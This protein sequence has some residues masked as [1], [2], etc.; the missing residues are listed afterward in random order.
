MREN[1]L[2]LPNPESKH[3]VSEPTKP[4]SYAGSSASGASPCRSIQ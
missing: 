3:T 2:T 4:S 1:P